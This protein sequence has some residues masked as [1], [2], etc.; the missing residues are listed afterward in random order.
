VP[1][2][3][4]TIKHALRAVLRGIEGLA[5]H[6]TM[7]AISLGRCLRGG[8][9]QARVSDGEKSNQRWQRKVRGKGW[10]ARLD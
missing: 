7:S 5:I 6:P 10:R 2:L 8:G 3:Y 9:S 1:H 4:F